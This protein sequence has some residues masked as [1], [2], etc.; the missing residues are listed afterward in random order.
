VQQ[1]QLV[2]HSGHL[3]VAGLYRVN[4]HEWQL[5]CR[6]LRL[7]RK[8]PQEPLLPRILLTVQIQVRHHLKRMRVMM[9]LRL[10]VPVQM[11]W[12]CRL[13][14]RLCQASK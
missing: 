10:S 9:S 14:Q 1:A 3:G 5:P 11:P 7:Q 4:R 6:R 2:P 12:P 13:L 8:Q